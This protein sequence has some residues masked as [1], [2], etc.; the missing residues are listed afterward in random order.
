MR[1]RLV[2]AAA[3]TAL[4]LSACG[5]DTD[6][7]EG[8][9]APPVEGVE[10]FDDLSRDHV[11]GEVDYDVEPPVGG[12]HSQVW[13]DCGVYDVAVPDENAVHSLEHGVV[14]F[15]HDPDLPADDFAELE[16]LHASRPDRVI[17]SPYPGIGSPVVAVAWGHR[18]AVD[19]ASDP[20]LAEFLDAFA[21]GS[22]APEPGA[23]CV[24]GLGLP[25]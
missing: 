8:T 13:L 4:V 25:G 14:W 20:R 16:A 22:A 19:S 10:V 3:V 18:L 21:N 23:P 7:D 6:D 2:T 24:G 15:A 12:D 11:D 5:D 1:S 17:V 9:I